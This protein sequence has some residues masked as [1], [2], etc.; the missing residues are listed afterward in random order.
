[1]ILLHIVTDLKIN[2]II[3]TLRL[4]YEIWSTKE[5]LI[6]AWLKW[7]KSN[8]DILIVGITIIELHFHDERYNSKKRK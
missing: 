7:N 5:G 6:T 8:I 3:T 1:M 2:T 4:K